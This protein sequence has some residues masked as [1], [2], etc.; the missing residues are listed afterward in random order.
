MPCPAS[1]SAMAIR[2]QEARWNA[3]QMHGHPLPPTQADGRTLTHSSEEL[4]LKSY[5]PQQSLAKQAVP[6]SAR[7]ALKLHSTFVKVSSGVHAE[8]YVLGRR[9]SAA[10]GAV[11]LLPRQLTGR[12]SCCVR[13][14]CTTPCARHVQPVHPPAHLSSISPTNMGAVAPRFWRRG[15]CTRQRT[16]RA[17][18]SSKR[19]GRQH[20]RLQT[21]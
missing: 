3:S 8:K 12:A 14:L 18:C 16:L 10:G 13:Q 7:L 19:W 17:P 20:G 4:P 15:T 2:H 21:P 5:E 9:G 11:G 6:G 1:D